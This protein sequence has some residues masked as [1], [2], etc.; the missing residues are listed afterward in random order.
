MG[1]TRHN[2]YEGYFIVQMRRPLFLHLPPFVL[3]RQLVVVIH[4]NVAS[5]LRFMSRH[6]L[7]DA[8]QQFLISPQ[9]ERLRSIAVVVKR[10]VKLVPD[11]AHMGSDAIFVIIVQC[12][13][14]HATQ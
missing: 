4:F 6:Q 10:V 2:S 11:G 1:K 3:K 5:F 13:N 12:E 7:C 9:F 8:W 14:Y